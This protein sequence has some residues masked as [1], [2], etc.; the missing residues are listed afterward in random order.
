MKVNGQLSAPMDLRDYE[1]S[2]STMV[3]QPVA[4]LFTDPYSIPQRLSLATNLL[5]LSRS[6]SNKAARKRTH[7]YGAFALL[8]ILVTGLQSTSSS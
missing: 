1:P 3:A 2:A 6:F 7:C 5:P 4:S 8:L